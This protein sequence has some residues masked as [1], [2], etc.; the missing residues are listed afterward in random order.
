MLSGLSNPDLLDPQ[1]TTTDVQAILDRA[2]NA[3]GSNDAIIAIVDRGGHVLGV[4]MEN[5]VSPSVQTDLA[6]RTFAIDGALALARTGAYF[7]NDQA[8]LT[9]RTIQFISQSTIVQREVDSSPEAPAN[10][11]TNGPGFVAPIGIKNHFPPNVPFTPQ[12]DLFLIEHTNRTTLPIPGLNGQTY[13]IDNRSYGQITNTLPTAQSRGIATLPGGLPIVKNGHVVGG[14]GIFF[15]GATGFASAENSTL[16]DNAFRNLQAPDRAQEAEYMAF[17]AVGGA[18]NANYPVGGTRGFGNLVTIPG[19]PGQYGF[20]LGFARIDLV[21]ITL[22]LFGGQGLQGIRNLFRVSNHLRSGVTHSYTDLPIDSGSTQYAHG[23]PIADGWIIQPH[24]SSDG[25]LTAADVVKMV[26]NGIN[27][28]N[29]TRAAIRAPLDQTARMVFA[30]TDKQGN[31]LG[32]YRMP[33]ATIFSVDVAV[34]KARNVAYYANTNELQPQDQIPGVPKGTAFTNRTFRYVSLPRFP[35]GINGYPP[36]PFSILNDPGIAKNGA[37]ITAYP[38][39]TYTSIQG[40]DAFNPGTNFHDP[41]DPQNQNGIVFFPGSTPLYKDL[42]SGQKQLVGGLGVSGD[43][44]D[45]DDVV[46]YAAGLG[47]GPQNAAPTADL[48]KVRGV[49]LP[50]MKFNR[51]PHE[52]LGQAPQFQAK[53]TIPAILPGS[54]IVLTNMVKTS[55]TGGSQT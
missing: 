21:G 34:A 7:G 36:G 18:A 16:N 28:A 40:H 42:G 15:P 5:G 14:I 32:L 51:Q 46:T 33:D 22:P 10:S 19:Q 54:K 25:S 12:V 37:T 35:E 43:G 20:T 1:L 47:F 2:I 24:D 30:V 53:P 8:P 55:T 17:Q 41:F 3:S 31:I 45:Q 13:Y 26:Q 50:Y 4:R 6:T 9:S 49:R 29:Q 48:F 11:I 27:E 38:P 23:Q 44:V 39:S 52:P